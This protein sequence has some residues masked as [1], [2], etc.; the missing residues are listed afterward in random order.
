LPDKDAPVELREALDWVRQ[1]LSGNPLAMADAKQ[2]KKIL[3]QKPT[4]LCKRQTQ[5]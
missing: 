5:K 3:R 2:L 4:D 1:A